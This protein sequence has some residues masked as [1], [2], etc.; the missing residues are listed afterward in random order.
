[1]LI[2]MPAKS[3]ESNE[4]IV[5]LHGLCRT[6]KSMTK[7]EQSLEKQGYH[8]LNVDYP[9]RKLEI[10]DLSEK[11]LGDA[12]KSCRSKGAVIIHFV[13]HS[14]G[15]ILI[16]DYLS[17]NKMPDLGRVVMLGPPNK[18]SEIVDILGELKLFEWINGTA[19]KNLGTKAGSVPNQL[20]PVRFSLGIIAGDRSVNW[21]NSA[22]I[23]GRD[24]GKVSV[25][26]TKIE[27]MSDHITL[28]VTH[29]YLMKNKESIRQTI[30]F[31]K[32]GCFDKSIK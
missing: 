24:D 10:T 27:G 12:V 11:Y 16:R 19:G 21:V 4:Y 13:A 5:L 17:R 8:V 31:L 29:P 26:N 30:A 23:S 28:H 22:M 32:E 2:S 6:A 18:G 9:S 25:E 1:M 7:M 14:L 15:G 3:A 20:G